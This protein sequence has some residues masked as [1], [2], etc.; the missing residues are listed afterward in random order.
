[1]AIDA[2]VVDGSLHK[3]TGR[4]FRVDGKPI[5]LYRR[6]AQ[7]VA[8]ATLA[9]KRRSRQSFVVTTGTGSGKSLKPSANSFE[10]QSPTSFS[11]IL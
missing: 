4:V 9:P 10:T 3:D 2:L 11:P 8:K 6:Q 1:M 5:T 7:A